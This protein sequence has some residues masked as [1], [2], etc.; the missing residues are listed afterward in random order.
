M[1][2]KKKF[3]LQKIFYIMPV[4]L[5]GFSMASLAIRTWKNSIND[6]ILLRI[7]TATIANNGLIGI[8]YF[9]LSIFAGVQKKHSLV[10]FIVCTMFTII[11]FY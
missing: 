10:A 6:D 9:A 4:T 2:N 3:L 11:A 5:W 1:N 7:L 8:Y